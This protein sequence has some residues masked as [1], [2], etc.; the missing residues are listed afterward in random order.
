MRS[1]SPRVGR[2][3]FTLIELLVVI[4][5]IAI[6]IGLLLPAVQKVR[7]AAARMSCQNQMK[8]LGL[9]LHGYANSYNQFPPGAEGAVLPKPNPAGN[10]TTIVGTSWI[11]YILPY[12]EQE[13][14]Y[15]QY[16]F[17]LDYNSVANGTVGSAFIP[18]LY[19]PSGPNPKQ[20]LD[21]NTNVTTNTSTHYYGVMGPGGTTNP[22]ANPTMPTFSYVVGSANANGAWSAHGILS[23]FTTTAGSVSTF[24]Q[25]RITDVTD[26]MSNTLMVG[27]RSM[28]VPPGTTNPFRTWI[29]GNNGG[30]GTT[31]NVTYPIN[32]ANMVYNGSNN[33]NDLAMGS[34][35]TG[36]ANFTMGDGSVRFVAQTIDMGIYMAAASIASGEVAPLP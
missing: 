5:I 34:L 27:E 1:S 11:V 2:P 31:K 3:G 23:H 24:R 25:I 13:N 30:S 33:F 16:N 4:A 7:D 8:Q 6:L 9:A 32:S 36:G 12:I 15:K 22:T 35:H 14:V 10:T 18:T 21:P 20:F 26:G 19:C 29:R 28:A 17:A